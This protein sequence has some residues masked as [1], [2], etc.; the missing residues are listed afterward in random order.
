MVL[1][2]IRSVKPIFQPKTIPVR[3]PFQLRA[4]IA[5]HTTALLFHSSVFGH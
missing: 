2:T 4:Q 5:D 1:K 3:S